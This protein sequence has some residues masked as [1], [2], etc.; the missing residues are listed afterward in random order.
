MIATSF[1]L[2]DSGPKKR[3]DSDNLRSGNEG[4]DGKKKEP[5]PNRHVPNDGKDKEQF[6]SV[7]GSDTKSKC[8]T[9]LDGLYALS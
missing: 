1:Q 7:F 3:N 9:L 8:A 2:L 4:K 6:C 5:K